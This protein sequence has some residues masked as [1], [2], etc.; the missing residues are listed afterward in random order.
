LKCGDIAYIVH[1]G[2]NTVS[3]IDRQTETEIE[4]DRDRDKERSLGRDRDGVRPADV[5]AD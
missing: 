1:V 5:R 3:Q 2:R 4:T